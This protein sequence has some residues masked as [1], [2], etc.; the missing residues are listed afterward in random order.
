MNK[1][2]VCSYAAMKFLVISGV[3]RFSLQEVK[4]LASSQ[5]LSQM[6]SPLEESSICTSAR[7]LVPLLY[8]IVS[9]T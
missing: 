2:S 6:Y 5:I 1:A 8:I 9:G 3:I 7:I 4:Y